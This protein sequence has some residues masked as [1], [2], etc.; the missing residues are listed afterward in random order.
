MLG[1]PLSIQANQVL[2]ALLGLEQGTGAV[3]GVLLPIA[4]QPPCWAWLSVQRWER[5][6]PLVQDTAGTEQHLMTPCEGSLLDA[7]MSSWGPLGK[8]WQL[9]HLQGLLLLL[10]LLHE[11]AGRLDLEQPGKAAA[12]SYG[13]LQT[14]CPRLCC[15]V[16][17][18]FTP[19]QQPELW[20][21][22]CNSAQASWW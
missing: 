6:Q 1:N 16:H 13:H 4:L 15:S 3:G 9:P 10:G 21:D 19:N 14:P 11:P 7:G 20:G 8:T 22:E 2:I 18:S 17:G 5:K 12:G